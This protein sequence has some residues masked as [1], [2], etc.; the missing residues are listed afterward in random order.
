MTHASCSSCTLYLAR[1]C[2][3]R[4]F[5]FPLL[6]EPLVAGMRLLGRLHGI[7][8]SPAE[9]PNPDCR[10]CLRH[11]KNRLKEVSPFF[12]LLNGLMNPL[13]NSLRDSLV[14]KEEKLTAKDFAAGRLNTPFQELAAAPPP[15][16]ATRRGH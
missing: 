15:G 2:Y 10:G 8:Y 1:L 9:G 5:W 6:R 7:D 12:V 11:L 14:S 3:R 13:F 16:A 4:S